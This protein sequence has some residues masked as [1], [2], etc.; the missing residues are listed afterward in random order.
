MKLER[1]LRAPELLR[2][3]LDVLG[4]GLRRAGQGD[5]EGAETVRRMGKALLNW[6]KGEGLEEVEKAAVS[7]VRARSKGLLKAGNALKDL[8][9]EIVAELGP[10]DS[11]RFVV[12]AGG[13]EPR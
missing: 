7:V 3:R 2:T 9:E 8:L 4:A 5:K 13:G 6:A 1:R 11:E 10:G 12:L